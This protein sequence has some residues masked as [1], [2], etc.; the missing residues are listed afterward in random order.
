MDS[1]GCLTTGQF[2]G[3]ELDFVHTNSAPSPT[4]TYNESYIFAC[5]SPTLAKRLRFA[6]SNLH[7]LAH[8]WFGTL[9][10]VSWWN[11]L[12]LNESVATFVAFLAM[13]RSAK[14][15]E[16]H[17]TCWVTFLEYKFWGVAKD[18]LS[19]THSICCSHVSAERA[20][21]L[22]DGISYGKGPSFIKQLY[23]LLGE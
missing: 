19:S 21:S 10:A 13:S 16:F 11:E 20:G 18:S 23:N 8:M 1:V 5:E 22:Y 17:S 14:L 6:I 3:Q 9:V 15:E 2:D 7:E 4:I 12:G